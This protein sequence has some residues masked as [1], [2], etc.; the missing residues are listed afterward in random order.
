[1]GKKVAFHTLGCKVNQYET[2]AMTGAF[3][4]AGYELVDF[5]ETADVYVINTC[6]VTNIGD[7]KSRQ[8][9]RRALEKNPEAFIAVVGCYAQIAPEKVQE[10][11]GVKLIVGTNERA[12]LV[13]LVES[14]AKETGVVNTVK[15]IMDVYEFED[16]GLTEYKG[17]TRAFVKIQEGCD[18]YCTYCIIPYARGHVRSRKPDS[19]LKEVTELKEKGFKE[20]VLTGIHIGSYGKDLKDTNL[21]E[22]LIDINKIDGIQRIRIGSVE[23]GTMSEEFLVVA[24][25]MDKLCKHFHLS[26]QS[27]SDATLKRMNR[28][29][30]AEQYMDT[31]ERIRHYMPEAAITTDLIVGFPG[32]T[33]EEYQETKAFVEKIKFSTVHVFKYSPREGTPAAKF[34]NQVSSGVKD[35]RSKEIISICEKSAEEY[36]KGFLGKNLKVLIEQEVKNLPGWFEGITENY[37]E[38][39]VKDHRENGSDDFKEIE[40]NIYSVKLDSLERGIMVGTA[41]FEEES[42]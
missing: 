10:I 39:R 42:S 13:Q 37:I 29:Y 9:I 16:L 41:F 35:E 22:L 23:P 11:P 38:V 36:K 15:S 18:Q 4:S 1:M 30:T 24:A 12:N 33:E 25:K 28:K 17:R 32:E 7:R 3:L 20:I 5:E 27:G 40:G 19:I 14:A 6:T 31:V 2:E 26:L 8:F 21:L 34:K